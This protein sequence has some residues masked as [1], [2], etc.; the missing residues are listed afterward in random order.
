MATTDLKETVSDVLNFASDKLTAS[1]SFLK[2][3]KEAGAEKMTGFVNDIL[4]LAPLIEVTGFNMKDVSVEVGIP[5]GLS[6]S[7]VK[8]KDVDADTINQLLEANKDKEMLKL[9]VRALLKA[10]SL[11]KGMNLS[12]YKFSGLSMKIGLPPDISLKFVRVTE[13]S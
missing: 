9:I 12:Q 3:A 8:E 6:I 13:N 5:P 4:G 11:Q 10:D 1:L 7:F 2:D